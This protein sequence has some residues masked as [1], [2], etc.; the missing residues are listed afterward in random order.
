MYLYYYYLPTYST[1]LELHYGGHI[2]RS[3]VARERAREAGISVQESERQVDLELFLDEYP[4]WGLVTPHQLVVLHKMFLHTMEQG[5]KEA[6][7]MFC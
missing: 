6:E 5:W 7:C 1:L 3:Q 2:N 4:R